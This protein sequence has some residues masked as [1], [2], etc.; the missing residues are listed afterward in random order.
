MFKNILKV[1]CIVMLVGCSPNDG[2]DQATRDEEK[3]VNEAQS[4]V[5]ALKFVKHKE[6]GLC[7]AYAWGGV[8]NG[9]P[10]LTE[11][12]CDKVEKLIK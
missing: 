5:N 4:L 12:P 11:V 6:S 3:A 10:A 7:F 2:K 1:M 8:G 9:G